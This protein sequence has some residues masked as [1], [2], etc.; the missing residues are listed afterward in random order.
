MWAPYYVIHKIMAGF[1]DQHQL[2][3]TEGALQA[4]EWMADYFCGRWG[5]AQGLSSC[6]PSCL[7]QGCRRRWFFVKDSC[8]WRRWGAMADAED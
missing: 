8:C 5:R 2:A 4:V 3:G 1:L 6:F 7:R